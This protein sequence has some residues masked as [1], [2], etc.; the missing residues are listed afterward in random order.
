[1]T[2]EEVH[3]ERVE[4]VIQIRDPDHPE[5][6]WSDEHKI[7]SSR[8]ENTT[9]YFMRYGKGSGFEF[10]LVERRIVSTIT[11]VVRVTRFS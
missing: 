8:S 11:D 2:Q 7:P 10:R 1:M 6:G 5:D 4:F 3:S 9:S